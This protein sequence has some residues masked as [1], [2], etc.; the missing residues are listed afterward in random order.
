M[1]AINGKIF[2]QKM[3]GL[4][5]FSYEIIKSLIEK[6][7]P[8]Q[9]MTP[10]L[11]IS[12]EYLDLQEYIVRDT[13]SLH[14]F[15]WEIF[16]LPSLLNKKIH[17]AL[18]SPANI[19][20]IHASVP[21]FLT[22]HDL[23]F[24][25]SGWINNLS[26]VLYNFFIPKAMSN[27]DKIV[28]VSDFIRQEIIEKY[29]HISP[30]K[31]LWIHSGCDHLKD[32]TILA[33]IG[34][35]SLLP[36]SSYFVMLGNIE[37]RKNFDRIVDAW[38][39][40]KSQLKF[41]VKLFIVGT[42]KRRENFNV[43]IASEDSSISITGRISDQEVVNLLKSARGLIFPSLYEGFG[44]P[45]LEA[46]K[47]GCPVITSN[48]GAMKEIA[49]DAAICVDPYSTECIS[50]AI[51]MLALDDDTY[52]RLKNDGIERSKLFTWEKST[53]FYI[54]NVFNI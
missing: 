21:H 42:K 18:W 45:I 23:A 10:N 33:E 38:E 54:E 31:V 48:I 53:K 39:I 15:L 22:L 7:I 29:T 27:A 5:R 3:T 12:T 36:N 8:F 37:S 6:E 16:R 47:C 11:P 46:M 40:S 4:G 24:L 17:N 20:P 13:V 52:L 28:C 49:G 2:T 1:L 26:Y 44:F 14:P 35:D 19:G 30:S 25:N 50:S 51:K 41:E 43:D 9:I 34:T 32:D